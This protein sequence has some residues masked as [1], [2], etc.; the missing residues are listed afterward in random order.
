[1]WIKLINMLPSRLAVFVI[2][3]LLD[4]VTFR[5]KFWMK[6]YLNKLQR[7]KN[8]YKTLSALNT[9]KFVP[10]TLYLQFI[11]E[12]SQQGSIDNIGG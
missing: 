10:S 8:Y 7:T 4:Y 11:E 6:Y 9:N 3:R 2:C 12:V 5:R 1:M